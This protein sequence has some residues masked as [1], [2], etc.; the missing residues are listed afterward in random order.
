MDSGLA[1]VVSSDA[2]IM[3]WIRKD[4]LESI[5]VRRKK[6]TEKIDSKDKVAHVEKDRSLAIRIVHVGLAYSLSCS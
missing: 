2:Y 5:S 1:K 6:S 3:K 4:R